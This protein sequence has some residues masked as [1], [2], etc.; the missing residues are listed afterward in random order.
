MLAG[1]LALALCGCG[2]DP[3][4]V[5]VPVGGAGPGGKADGAGSPSD[6]LADPDLATA[7]LETITS[8]TLTKFTLHTELSLGARG[9][10]VLCPDPQPLSIGGTYLSH[11]TKDA[12]GTSETATLCDLDVPGFVVSAN[13]ALGGCD[14]TRDAHLEAGFDVAEVAQKSFL[15]VPLANLDAMP[16]AFIL[17]AALHDPFSEP[18]PDWTTPDQWRDDDADGQPGI[19]LIATGV[20]LLPDGAELYTAVRLLVTPTAP[21]QASASLE[22]ALLGSNAGL[23][24][25]TL[26][27]IAPDLRAGLV[28]AFERAEVPE[29]TTCAD[30]GPV[31]P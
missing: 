29:G 16:V 9:T 12:D 27:V 6:P 15:D 11:V 25:Q 17:G 22:M 1:A 30:V 20:P 28:V 26:N 3:G 2:G 14:E 23:S 31:V 7:P 24:G 18:L 21:G 8:T 10:E 4:A 19:T 5:E 13:G